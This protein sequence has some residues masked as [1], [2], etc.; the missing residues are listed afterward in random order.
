VKGEGM[1]AEFGNDFSIKDHK[2][3]VE[4][5]PWSFEI[6]SSGGE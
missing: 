2:L 6:L 1:Q 5:Q 4:I 3:Q